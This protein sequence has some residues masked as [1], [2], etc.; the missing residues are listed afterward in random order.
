MAT[1]DDSKYAFVHYAITRVVQG[2]KKISSTFNADKKTLVFI[3]N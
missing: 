3:G 1:N 2:D